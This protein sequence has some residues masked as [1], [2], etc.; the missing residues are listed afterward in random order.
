MHKANLGHLEMWGVFFINS[1]LNVI[2]HVVSGFE[3][4]IELATI[5][6]IHFSGETSGKCFF[7]QVQS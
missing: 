5:S 6:S 3:V 1:F 7:P 4:S 2:P